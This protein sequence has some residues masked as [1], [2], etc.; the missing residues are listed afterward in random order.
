MKFKI[1]YLS[2][3]G[4]EDLEL[5]SRG[6]TEALPPGIPPIESFG[7]LIRDS[8]EKVGAGLAGNLMFGSIYTSLLWVSLPLRSQ[9]CGRLLMEEVEALGKSKN[10]GF[11]TVNTFS[12]QALPFY[13]HLGYQ[14]E[15]ERKGYVNGAINYYLRKQF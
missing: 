4:L 3:L 12:F 13:L 11:A 5:I 10:C 1:D 15:F 7:F 8:Q 2:K 9:G 14:I 6:L